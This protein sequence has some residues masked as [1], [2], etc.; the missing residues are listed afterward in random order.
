MSY[1]FN[2]SM[3]K[4]TSVHPV[5]SEVHGANDAKSCEQKFRPPSTPR[6]ELLG[7]HLAI[8]DQPQSHFPVLRD[9]VFGA[10]FASQNNV[11]CAASLDPI[12]GP[13]LSVSRSQEVAA[14]AE[15]A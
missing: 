3:P 8:R 12:L 15:G 11:F 4:G 14:I 5:C 1:K 10:Y 6:D 7:V 2:A 9:N 13:V